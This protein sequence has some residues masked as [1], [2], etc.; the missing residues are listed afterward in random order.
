MHLFR[1]NLQSPRRIA[2]KHR[3]TKNG[4]FQDALLG[5]LSSFRQIRRHSEGVFV[6]RHPGMAPI[7]TDDYDLVA[8]TE[9]VS[10][11]YLVSFFF[12]RSLACSVLP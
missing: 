1:E 11:T 7:S 3:Q 5:H 8:E 9:K 12:F 10:V 6:Q 4:T 2:A